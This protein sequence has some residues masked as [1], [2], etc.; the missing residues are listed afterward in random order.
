[1]LPAALH[2]TSANFCHAELLFSYMN[3]VLCYRLAL[4]NDVL[5]TDITGNACGLRDIYLRLMVIFTS[6]Y[7]MLWNVYTLFPALPH[8]LDKKI[9]DM[10]YGV[11]SVWAKLKECCTNIIPCYHSNTLHREQ[12]LENTVVQVEQSL[13]IPGQ[14]P[15]VPGGWGSQISRQSAHEGGTVVS[16]TNRLPLPHEKYCWYTFLSQT[17]SQC[18]ARRIES[19]KNSDDTTGNRTCNLLAYSPEKFGHTNK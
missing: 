13:C 1:M 19:M 5:N 7:H 6:T 3:T 14:V 4:P 10:T 17:D 16:P 8:F 18:T 15:R 11:I 2:G 12:V 9:T